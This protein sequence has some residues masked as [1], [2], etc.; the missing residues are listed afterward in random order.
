MTFCVWKT[1]Y[2]NNSRPNNK[3]TRER[4]HPSPEQA[5]LQTISISIKLNVMLMMS[6]FL[7]PTAIPSVGQNVFTGIHL[8]KCGKR[9]VKK[10]HFYLSRK[11]VDPSTAVL[12]LSDFVA[13][14]LLKFSEK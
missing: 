4:A 2:S 11:S 9:S 12:F 1:G 8:K 10:C 14:L 3:A 5:H 6:I 13:S 7:V